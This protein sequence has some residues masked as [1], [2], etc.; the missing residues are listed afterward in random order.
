MRTVESIGHT[1]RA[2]NHPA[3]TNPE[4]QESH[5]LKAHRLPH[6][7]WCKTDTHTHT[8]THTHTTTTT[9]TLSHDVERRRRAG[10]CS[11]SGTITCD[12]HTPSPQP[13]SIPT[14]RPTLGPAPALRSTPSQPRP[15]HPSLAAQRRHTCNEM[16][17]GH[18]QGEQTRHA[19]ALDRLGRGAGAS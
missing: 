19:R 17:R 12:A 4:T 18:Q 7:W 11:G 1:A 15:P 16:I 13:P 14:T 2:R 8:H 6:F 10:A 5:R 3:R 9:T